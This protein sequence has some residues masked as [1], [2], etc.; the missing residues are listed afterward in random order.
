MDG[1]RSPFERVRVLQHS[2]IAEAQF[3]EW[4]SQKIRVPTHDL[5]IAAICVAERAKLVSRNRRDFEAIPG[6]EV[7]FW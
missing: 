7:E 3:Q 5:R 6:L 1:W 4:R 2:A